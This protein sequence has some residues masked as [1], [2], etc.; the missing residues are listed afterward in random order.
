[1]A[2]TL[3]QSQSVTVAHAGS[4]TLIAH[5]ALNSTGM[6]DA[7]ALA[8]PLDVQKICDTGLIKEGWQDRAPNKSIV[9][10]SHVAIVSRKGNPKNVQKWD[11][12]IR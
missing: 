10:E 3:Q 8:L 5:S 4:A 1:M 2:C 6:H 11:D 12:L 7:V 9:C